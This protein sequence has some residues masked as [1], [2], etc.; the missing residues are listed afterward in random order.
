MRVFFIWR[1]GRVLRESS[2]STTKH[3]FVGRRCAVAAAV[4]RVRRGMTRSPKARPAQSLPQKLRTPCGSFL[5]GG[6]GSLK[7]TCLQ[8]KVAANSE[9]YREFRWLLRFKSCA[10]EQ[11]PHPDAILRPSSPS[12]GKMRNRELIRAY[13][14]ICREKQDFSSPLRLRLNLPELLSPTAAQPRLN[15]D[16]SGHLIIN[17]RFTE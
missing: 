6:G 9:K 8:P 12:A 11:K 2:G 5:F 15:K 4:P 7:R 10:T 1:R 3:C 17:W 13:Q 16:T 14:G